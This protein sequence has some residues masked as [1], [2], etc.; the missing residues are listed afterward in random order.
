MDLE[1]LEWKDIK[2][3]YPKPEDKIILHTQAIYTGHYEVDEKHP[4]KGKWVMDKQ[5]ILNDTRYAYISED[6]YE[7]IKGEYW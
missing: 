1:K 3:G 6:Q 7:E 2:D 5:L 4:P